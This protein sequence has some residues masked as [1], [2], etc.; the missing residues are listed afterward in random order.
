MYNNKSTVHF[1]REIEINF[2][3]ICIFLR[4]IEIHFIIM[5]FLCE[6]GGFASLGQ[7]IYIKQHK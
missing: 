4:E 1:L 3:S 7:Y 2:L 5:H 6:I